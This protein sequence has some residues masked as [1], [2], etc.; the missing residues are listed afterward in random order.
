[1]VNSSQGGGSK[2]TWVLAGSD[3]LVDPV[4][5]AQ[6]SPRGVPSNPGPRRA[7]AFGLLRQQMA[8][9][10]QGGFAC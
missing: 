3:V 9:Q 2:D 6:N 10:Q 7:G 4:H 1:V 5:A 8:Q